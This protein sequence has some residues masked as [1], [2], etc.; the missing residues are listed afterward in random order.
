MASCLR[1]TGTYKTPI[2]DRSELI[3]TL[4]FLG[5][6]PRGPLETTAARVKL[7]LHRPPSASSVFPRRGVR[8]CPGLWRFG[9]RRERLP[10]GCQ[11]LRDELQPISAIAAALGRHSAHADTTQLGRHAGFGYRSRSARYAELRR[12]G[13]RTAT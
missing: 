7:S 3:R 12:T 8:G 4:W 9:G 10:G 2:V 13:H 6:G 11:D 1:S 5:S